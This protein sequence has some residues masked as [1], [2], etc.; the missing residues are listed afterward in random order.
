MESSTKNGF[1]ITVGEYL[2]NKDNDLLTGVGRRIRFDSVEDLSRLMMQ[3]KRRPSWWSAH[4]W[5]EDRRGAER[6]EAASCIG[7]DLDYSA[8][9]VVD[10]KGKGR[11]DHVSPPA[12]VRDRLDTALTQLA[13]AAAPLSKGLVVAHHTPRGARLV[14]LLNA[15]IT[16]RALF[17]RA[18]A[19]ADVL[20]SRWLEAE[21]LL[22][23]DA[24]SVAASGPLTRP[25]YEVDHKA[26]TDPART[27]LTPL[28]WKPGA[29]D[30]RNDKV[31][32]YGPSM[33]DRF[34]AH[35]L[36]TFAPATPATA[37]KPPAD[38]RPHALWPSLEAALLRTPGAK[39]S[40]EKG[41]SIRCPIH[42]E[43][44]NPS[45][46]VFRSGVLSCLASGCEANE[47]QQLERWAST[48]EGRGLLG[49]ELART[50][51]PSTMPAGRVRG[52][53]LRPFW[54][55]V[56]EWEWIDTP[57]APMD[58]LLTVP[59]SKAYPE[60][61]HVLPR[62]IVGM[63]AAGG[64]VGKSMA[65][66]Q[67]AVAV[68]SETPWLTGNN[69]EGAFPGFLTHGTTGKV[70]LALGEEDS[71]KAH[72]RIHE[73]A[74]GLDPEQK[75]LLR[76]RLVVLPLEGEPVGL[77]ADRGA[78]YGEEARAGGVADELA[79]L[80]EADGPWALVILDP[81]SR[82]AGMETETDNAVATRFVQT[83]E[84]FT[85]APGRPTV[86]VSHHTGQAARQDGR[87]D[88]TAARG[89][90]G[91]TD[92]VRWVATLTK[93]TPKQAEEA[94]AETQTRAPSMLR[95]SVSKNNYGLELWPFWLTR[96]GGGSLRCATRHEIDSFNGR[97]ATKRN[98]VQSRD[99]GAGWGEL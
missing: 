18:A 5:S 35:E 85:K 54:R 82:F 76:E 97:N 51:A 63:L 64:G 33:A 23:G 49:D 75:A 25:G 58:W 7:L 9:W 12:T 47:G 65:L 96:G 15:P 89:A 94:T 21:G 32:E 79:Q 34:D 72:R 74:L 26:A 88:S 71:D 81:L 6:W 19:G 39:A 4:T 78:R 2:P 99:T 60:T 30:P 57:P 13:G 41:V 56:G 3:P 83:L 84:R 10:D 52:E 92:G 46:I 80:L 87:H 86:L 42:G 37:P 50:V 45:A 93:E 27:L 11:K 40:P 68:A 29:P 53:T 44:H 69:A 73:A 98:P 62:G 77:M 36:A 59:P 24:L 55:T 28:A 1:F 8:A 67:L 16:D 91:L 17:V 70:L 22:A 95:M 20:V 66:V 48:P 90:T 61:R 31:A 38:H 14:L 43:D